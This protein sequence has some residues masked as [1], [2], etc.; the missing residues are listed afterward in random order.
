MGNEHLQG[1]QTLQGEGLTPS[2]ALQGTEVPPKS[3]WQSTTPPP[4]WLRQ[5]LLSLLRLMAALSEIF[6][7]RFLREEGVGFMASNM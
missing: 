7:G 4:A 5:E 3:Q 2:S 1:A 6:A